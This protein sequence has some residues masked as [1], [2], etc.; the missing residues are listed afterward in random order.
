[1][2]RSICLNGQFGQRHEIEETQ[3]RF[4]IRTVGGALADGIL[5]QIRGLDQ[6]RANIEADDQFP[7]SSVFVYKCVDHPNLSSLRDE[8]KLII[9]SANQPSI[10]YAGSVMC[11]ADSGIYQLYT[12]NL[13]LKFR[14]GVRQRFIQTILEQNHL[15]VKMQLGFAE[16][17]LFVEADSQV[18]RD[19]FDLALDLL[20][21][22]EVEYCHPEMVVRR[23]T[24]FKNIEAAQQLTAGIH[25]DWVLEKIGIQSAW[26]A[27]KGRGIRICI[28]DDGLDFE[29]IGF[30]ADGRIP[31]FK[32][33]L[34][35]TG[36]ARPTHQ[37]AEGHG[38]ACASI[39]CSSDPRAMGV[40]PEAQLMPIRSL[41]L[42]SVLEAQA[43]YWAAQ[44]GADIISCS[45]GPPDG[46]FRNKTKSQGVFPIPDHTN[47][48]IQYAATQG[49]KGKGCLI[50]FAAGNGNENVRNDQYASHPDVWAIGSTNIVNEKAVYGDYGSPLFCSFPSGD[51]QLM[52]DKWKQ[53]Y[54]V[55]VADR[56]GVAGFS[57]DDIYRFFAGT[58]ASCP[59]MAGLAALMLSV[60][61]DLTKKEAGEILKNSCK[62]LGPI[63]E[64]MKDGYHSKFGYGLIQADLLIK[65][66]LSFNH[67]TNI[68][69]MKDNTKNQGY[70][71]HIGIDE[72][73]QAYY[74]G[75]IPLLHGCVN[76]MKRMEK[77][78]KSLDYITTALI[79]DQATKENINA[80]LDELST[81]AVAGDTVLIS[82]AGHGASIRDLNGDEPDGLDESWV[83]Y[84]G[85]LLDDDINLALNKFVQGV[86]VIMVSDSCHSGTVSRGIPKEMEA[87]NVTPRF[88]PV[89]IV[90][91]VLALHNSTKIDLLSSRSVKEEDTIS[92]GLILLAACQD[93]QVAGEVNAA[94]IFTSNLFNVLQS[95]SGKSSTYNQLM[96]RIEKEM[97]AYQKPRMEY[98]GGEQFDFS[99]SAAFLWRD[100]AANNGQQPEP[101]TEDKKLPPQ[102]P[103]NVRMLVDTDR[104]RLSLPASN[105]SRSYRGQSAN[106]LD[107]INGSVDGKELSGGTPWD[108]AYHLLLTNPDS[109]IKW[110]EPDLTSNIYIDPSAMKPD[111]ASRGGGLFGWLSTYPPMQEDDGSV[112]FDWHLDNEHSQ[113]KAARELVYPELI[114][115]LPFD[116]NKRNVR[117]GHID[118]GI[119]ANHPAH[120]VNFKYEMSVTA[121]KDEVDENAFDEDVKLNPSEQQGHGNATLAILAGRKIS[122][123]ESD[124]HF[125]DYF[126]GA[127][128]AEVISIKISETVVLLSGKRF[129][130]AIDYAIEQK[131][132]VITMSLS[133]WPSKVMAD[134]V[135]RAY[136]AG[137]VI[138]CAGS[139]SWVKGGKKLIPDSILYPAR[140]DR[141]IG[142]VGSTY[143]QIPYVYELHHPV[144]RSEGGMYMQMSYGPDS[145]MKT[146]VAGYSPN[147]IWFGHSID[148]PENPVYVKN[149]G[150]TSSATPQVAAACALYIQHH[151]DE[152]E[153]LAGNEKWKIV[154]MVK[155]AIFS[156]AAKDD[157]YKTYYGNGV[158]RARKALDKKPSELINTISKSPEAKNEGG[159]FKKLVGLFKR[160][161]G[162]D[163][164]DELLKE[165][166]AAEI[167][168]LIHREPKLFPL[169]H[170]DFGNPE[171]ELS[172]EERALLM[173]GVQQSVK[174]S[175]FLKQHLISD[176]PNGV[177]K[178]LRSLQFDGSGIRNLQFSSEKSQYN[179]RTTGQSMELR[180]F[181]PQV[182]RNESN[183]FNVD[184]F[185]FE[186]QGGSGRDVNSALQLLTDLDANGR[187]GAILIEREING[188]VLYEWQFDNQNSSG[189]STGSRGVE[190]KGWTDAQNGQFNIA[191]FQNAGQKERGLLDTG[192]KVV[193]KVISW[194]KSKKAKNKDAQWKEW[195]S[196]S[197]QFKYE[198][199]A[200]DLNNDN[201]PGNEWFRIDQDGYDQIWKS[202]ADD[203]KPALLLFPGLFRDVR[204]N[205]VDLLVHPSASG[206]FKKSYGRYI[207]G[208]NMP[209]VVDGIQAN[210]EKLHSLVQAKLKKKNCSVIARSRGGIVA[211]YLFENTWS[212]DSKS[213]QPFVLDKMILVATPNTGTPIARNELWKDLVTRTTNLL[214]K[215]FSLG[216]PVFKGVETVLAAIANEVADLPGI[217]DLEVNSELMQR[218]NKD[219]NTKK[220]YY[221]VA[222]D[223]EPSNAIVR[224]LDEL[225]VDRYV[226]DGL[227]NDGVAPVKSVIF[228]LEKESNIIPGENQFLL[229][230]SEYVNHFNYFKKNN[231]GV[232]LWIVK[233]LGK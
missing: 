103:R 62:N 82:Y 233:N 102:S 190:S 180:A 207:I 76:D 14:K 110:V 231:D 11:Y 227:N 149:G 15:V 214:G 92:A 142:V 193:V 8:I 136:E 79:N 224:L 90:E 220:N 45:W 35:K 57:P 150:G 96:S 74:Q 50:F 119:L 52:G 10:K 226:F 139:N 73:S 117:V 44:N 91:E 20:L 202:I 7:E 154:E 83:T 131:V 201:N 162:Y 143:N 199:L 121:E 61:P 178:G 155:E 26:A 177:G 141:T 192:V 153:R 151:R 37:F 118:T 212:A 40:A 164:N 2:S 157:Q 134:A 174:A 133:G 171:L 183:D 49:R 230:K 60:K 120:P 32:D 219:I 69:K 34:D 81:R 208:F 147:I 152:L 67:T 42:G 71:L 65:N 17:A 129:A 115:G 196:Q 144:I 163:S 203:P 97:P 98:R 168:Q 161:I 222:S 63:E 24:A 53:S 46:D 39:A 3:D 166:M 135:N 145:A 160:S 75:K 12:G 85:F 175:E 124:V 167:V 217:D 16:N 195:L 55:T 106:N 184:E 116:K 194:L 213:A 28:I 1:M 225:M 22:P 93:D 111:T 210:A 173:E 100:V 80:K 113:L 95:E 172:S 88:V 78:A 138:C 56:S 186:I 206:E 9:R 99:D 33:M 101:K 132:D 112:A 107:V 215:A 185:E 29:H 58:S 38:T 204:E 125:N 156:S 170:L 104:E 25:D 84:S 72:V 198:I 223:F 77:F 228:S 169:L 89:E 94:G 19:I 188:E 31:A 27:T 182:M 148:D 59:G 146:V 36:N 86:K 41:G 221:I 87:T 232:I 197:R 108:K 130:K 114:S 109:N 43:F 4:V 123:K 30:N 229:G 137:I 21:L 5:S 200:Y 209:D 51:Y 70:S 165:M 64:R 189:E 47:L 211:R 159:F 68:S 105:S 179:L 18:G 205:F 128:L 48:A 23:M 54:G 126:G 218:L 13:F 140:Y 158:L 6:Y 181:R 187:Q 191:L 216:S 66:T 122:S 176:S 127:P